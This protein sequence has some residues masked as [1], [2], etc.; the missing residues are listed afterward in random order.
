MFKQHMYGGPM[1]LGDPNYR[2]LSKMEEDPMIP[3]RMRD[4]TRTQLCIPE[5]RAFSECSKNSGFSMVFQCQA[6]K[7]CMVE[8]QRQWMEDRP[9]FRAAVKEE[10]LNERSHYRQTGMKQKR[11]QRGKFI[12]R[13]VESDPT[14]D[15]QGNYR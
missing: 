7:N 10:Y 9:E 1:G 2:E 6:E 14:L 11:Y 3:Q 15:S 12:E 4:I 5:V 13:D 8:C